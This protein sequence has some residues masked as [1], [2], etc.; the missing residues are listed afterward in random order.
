MKIISFKLFCFFLASS[1]VCVSAKDVE[2]QFNFP[3]RAPNYGLVYFPQD[4]SAAANTFHV[5]QKGKLFN[6]NIL[7]SPKGSKVVF[8]NQDDVQHNIFAEDSANGVSFDSGLVEPNT[9]TEQ[10]VTWEEGTVVRVGCKIHPKMQIWLASI[11][12]NY[13]DVIQFKE[14]PNS[15]IK[16]VPDELTEI[17][18]WIPNFDSAEITVAP[19]ETKSVPITR[20]KKEFGTV[21][22]KR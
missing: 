14:N 5:D 10:T 4:K 12:S 16:D 7:C 13:F 17:K 19:G 20:K 18:I 1:Y 15:T 3:K 11:S 22:I 8:T 6:K 21:T 9:D 2:I